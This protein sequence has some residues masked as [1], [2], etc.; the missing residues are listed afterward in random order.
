VY[1][2]KS[3][4]I[5]LTDEGR[6]IPPKTPSAR[7]AKKRKRKDKPPKNRKKCRLELYFGQ[8]RAFIFLDCFVFICYHIFV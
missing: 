3:E 6:R 4:P 7:L 1:L 8:M 5:L 2:K